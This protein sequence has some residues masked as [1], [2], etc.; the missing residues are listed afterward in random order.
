MYF[1]FS[2]TGIELVGELGHDLDVLVG[3]LAD[4]YKD[5]IYF[6]AELAPPEETTQCKVPLTSLEPKINICILESGH[7][8]SHETYGY[9]NSV[10]YGPEHI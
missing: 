10:K 3:E 9:W 2:N 1:V 8:G 5:C 7:D 4:S 6:V